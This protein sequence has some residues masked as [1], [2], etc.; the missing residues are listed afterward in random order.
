M[1]SAASDGG[2]TC[3]SV[4]N[5]LR[6]RR[7]LAATADRLNGI[8]GRGRETVVFDRDCDSIGLE[9]ARVETLSGIEKEGESGCGDWRSLRLSG[10]GESVRV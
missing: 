6:L 1:K 3:Q 7:K 9:E 2:R 5:G 10:T 8:A 4:G